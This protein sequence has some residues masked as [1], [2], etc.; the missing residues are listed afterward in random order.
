MPVK[1]KKKVLVL[2]QLFYPELISTGQL[3]TEL[4]ENLVKFGIEV[5]VLCGPPTLLMGKY[6][7]PRRL[8]YKGIMIRRVWGTTFPKLVLIGKLINQLTYTIS[9][10]CYLFFDFSRRPIIVLTDPPFLVIACAILRAFGGK[11]YIYV[12]FDVHPDGEIKLGL[13]K[14]KSIIVRLW[15]FANRFAIKQASYVTVLGRCMEKLIYNKIWLTNNIQEKI[16]I[17]HIWCDDKNIVPV[18][19]GENYF[20]SKF[21]LEGK[22]II[23]YAGNF[24]RYHDIEKIMYAVKELNKRKDIFF[25]FVGEGQKKK[26][27]KEYVIRHSLHNCNFYGYVEREELKYL[28]S[29]FH[30]GLVSLMAGYEGV[31]V[32]SKVVSLLAAGVP[33]LGMIPKSSEMALVV[34]EENCGILVEPGDVKG[35]VGAIMKLYY[36]PELRK[37]MGENGRKAVDNKYNLKNVVLE[38]RDLIVSL[39]Y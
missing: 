24:G 11:P 15:E 34:A 23:G 5:E 14:E 28:L 12:T 16:K 20:I 22:F 21:N 2:C 32:P 1:N 8:S 37:T 7:A 13:L 31:A 39:Q 10:F 18:E 25:I 19:R 36:N 30:V 9:T 29:S 38:Y 17:I 3:L 27:A 26:W 6:K 4:C 33:I 35:L